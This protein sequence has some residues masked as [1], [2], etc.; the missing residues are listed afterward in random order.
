MKSNQLTAAKLRIKAPGRYTD[1]GGLMLLVKESGARSWVLRVMVNGVRRDIGLG[2]VDVDRQ[3]GVA[4][5]TLEALPLGR[6]KLLT[7]A[8][9]RAKA[10]EGR[11]L[12]KAGL[13]PSEVWAKEAVVVPTFEKKATDFWEANKEHWRNEK[14][15]EQWLQ[16][17]QTYAFPTLKDKRVDEIDAGDISKAI[18][19]IWLTKPETADRV[20]QRICTVLTAAKAGKE[21]KDAVPTAKE[22]REGLPRRTETNTRQEENLA[23]MPYRDL[24]ALIQRVRSSPVTVARLALLFVFYTAARSGEVRGMTWSEVDLDAATWTVP[25]SRMKMGRAHIVTLS[26]PAVAVLRQIGEL[27]GMKPGAL[28]F[29]GIN[30][31][32]P[33]SD[34]TIAKAFKVAGGEG[35][36]VHGSSRSGFRDWVAESM[37]T[38]E[39]RDD[40]GMVK[41]ASA[42]DVAE[43]ALAHALPNRVEASYRRTKFLE[44]RRVLMPLWAK[45]LDGTNNVVALRAVRK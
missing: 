2:S 32:K 36:T 40:R 26:E 20:Q 8:E 37:T 33:M 12:A 14:H 18:V 35:F 42:G 15:R 4:T 41:L 7:L 28:V 1:G 9:A 31:G 21:R 10:A 39:F 30:K 38:V 6:R 5:D 25:A 22:I 16:S 43:A 19:G 11:R 17:L 23:A 13:N 34:A 24:P 44:H 27:C 3:P 45:H 29:P